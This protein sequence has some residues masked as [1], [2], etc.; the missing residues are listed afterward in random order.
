MPAKLRHAA[1]VIDRL[2]V[3][4]ISVDCSTFNDAPIVLVP[5]HDLARLVETH[6]AY[7]TL[8]A[9][10]VGPNGHASITVYGVRVT[11]VIRMRERATD[12]AA[13]LRGVSCTA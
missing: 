6:D 3:D 13:L 4:P 1:D 5:P 2:G 10:E 8:T 12:A 9:R 7:D 11:S